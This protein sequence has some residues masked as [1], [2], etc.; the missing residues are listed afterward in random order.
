MATHLVCTLVRLPESKQ[1][2]RIFETQHTGQLVS[3]TSFLTSDEDP[4]NVVC[5]VLKLVRIPADEYNVQSHTRQLKVTKTC[6]FSG[7]VSK[8]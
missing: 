3:A 4:T 5:H 8:V 2:K 7:S 1:R 6:M